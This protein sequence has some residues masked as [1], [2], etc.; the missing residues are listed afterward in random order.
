MAIIESRAETASPIPPSPNAPKVASVH[1]FVRRLNSLYP[2]Q[3]AE[4]ARC[5]DLIDDVRVIAGNEHVLQEQQASTEALV[6]LEGLACHYRIM[7]SGRRQMT[8]IVVPGDFCD[9]GF[10]SS[11]PI[12]QSVQAL[13]RA[14]V[15]RINLAQ[16]SA[17]TE[18]HPNVVVAI[19][20]AASIDQACSRELA[21]SL[22]ARDAVQR[23]SYF[24][25]ELYHRM[26]VVG[27]VNHGG[28]FPLTMTQSELGEA[29]G[30][31]T[32]HVNRTV[33]HLRRSKLIAMVHGTITVL[34]IAALSALA[35][36]DGRYLKPS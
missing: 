35:S 24:L 10:L 18:D 12:R 27:L 4:V 34:D 20:R 17:L 3:A 15:G 21:V 22:G 31:S 28:Q 19:M 23:M 7:D 16:L 32:V 14:I 29:L 1:A 2:L 36:F 26:R 11:S 25:C 30:L 6:L 8:G 9:Y 33:Q 13:G 5:V